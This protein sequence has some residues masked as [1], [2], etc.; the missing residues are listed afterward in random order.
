MAGPRKY[1]LEER[2]IN[3]S[4]LILAIVDS[5]PET[6]VCNHLGNQL[7]RSGTSAALNY[8][9]AQGAESGKDF[10]HKMQIV[11]KELRETSVCLKILFRRNIMSNEKALQES[12]ELIAIFT[13][14]VKTAKASINK[15]R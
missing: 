7:L 9:E 2:L 1:D 13:V 6:R 12:S 10:C 5:L 15:S 14:S 3:F 11:L 8:G 4:L